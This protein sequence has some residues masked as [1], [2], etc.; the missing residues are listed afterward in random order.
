MQEVI[1]K[2]LT[3]YALYDTETSS[4]LMTKKGKET[5][6]SPGLA[7]TAFSIN[8]PQW[9]KRLNVKSFVDQ[10]RVV[11]VEIEIPA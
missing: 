7:K 3:I 11:V 8:K 9:A 1:G 5:W 10:D 4:F 2:N 6:K